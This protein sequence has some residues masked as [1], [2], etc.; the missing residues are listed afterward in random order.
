MGPLQRL[1]RAVHAPLVLRGQA[2]NEVDLLI[3]KDGSLFPVEC[4]L[5]E[6]PTAK[7][8]KG[9]ARLRDFYGPNQVSRAY[10]S[11]PVGDTFDLQPDVTVL[12]G[13]RTWPLAR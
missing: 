7:D 12:P 3:E 2:G 5:R 10:M 8:V 11:C 1:A 6:S 9:I 13:W 4:N